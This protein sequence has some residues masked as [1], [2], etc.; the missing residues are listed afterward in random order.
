MQRARGIAPLLAGPW[1]VVGAIV[2]GAFVVG[3]VYTQR[4]S[5]FFVMPDELGYVKQ[6]IEIARS[7]WL[8]T[9]GDFFFNSYSQLQPLL[10]A[11]AYAL[12][13]GLKAFDTAHAIN[14]AVQAT[15]AIPAYLLARRILPSRPAAYAVALLTVI[16]P[17]AVMS[18]SMMSE[19]AAYPASV[20][21]TLA[22]QRAL[23]RPSARG[24]LLALL[25]IGVAF[26]A[27]SQ[28][29][30]LGVAFVAAIVVH[31]LGHRLATA[32]AGERRAALRAG[33]VAAVRGHWALIAAVACLLAIGFGTNAW[34]SLLGNYVT[35]QSGQLL[36]PGTLAKGFE[37][38]GNVVIAV[39][40]LPLLLTLA[41]VPLTL[42]R[43]ADREQ[44]AFGALLLVY[45]PLMVVVLGSFSVRFTAGPNDRY[46]FYVL[47]LLFVAMMAM[48]LDRR[49]N[50]AS[51]LVGAGLTAWLTATAPFALNVPSMVAPSGAF[52]AVLI[53]RTAQI[54]TALGLEHLRAQT[55]IAVATGMVAVV[56]VALRTRV[57]PGRVTVAA[58][59]L[60]IGFT[61]VETIYTA[62]KISDVQ[63]GIPASAIEQRAW[64]DKALGRNGRA[65]TV[66]SLIS[67]PVSASGVLWETSF[68]NASV[69]NSFVLS[70]A[71]I[72]E[73]GAVTP[74][75][76]DDDGNLVGMEGWRHL[77]VSTLDRR[78]RISGA[79]V[80]AKSDPME[81][82]R[83]PPRPRVD[84]SMQAADDS[85]LTPLGGSTTIRLY[86]RGGHAERRRIA[87]V[88]APDFQATQRYR[89]RLETQGRSATGS[90]VPKV[91][92]VQTATVNVP[93]RGF[94][95][96]RLVAL[97]R[98]SAQAP[99][100]GAGV[101]VFDVLTDRRAIAA[102]QRTGRRP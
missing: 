65:A 38:L 44:H 82:L 23:A 95:E 94:A 83:V 55:L 88:V 11:P 9:R 39:A 3:L 16:T 31:E 47:P 42:G 91:T 78:F 80:E 68:W 30:L 21:A 27:R 13:G 20:W 102:A 33:A 24:D 71:P 85:G 101:V 41:W 97:R 58:A 43:P 57:R 96:V 59:L 22:V 69:R 35:V 67:D 98:R 56:L 54:G 93:A 66:I 87:L 6:A 19:N 89:Y 50:R 25:G 100:P 70:G 7:G 14:A 63:A 73:Q 84:W 53:G 17:W 61:L 15:T 92:T 4:L 37:L 2:L 49:P 34:T 40:C 60:V 32:P 64:I 12:F 10:M 75:H 26:F 72:Y 29:Y 74:F 46:M 28:L 52:H 18:G 36:P 99:A 5:E 76:I 45:L 90:A 51:I 62:K 86:A 48:L 8:S 77:A 1:A 81:L 79:A